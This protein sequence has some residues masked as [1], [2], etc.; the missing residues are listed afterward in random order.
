MNAMPDP[1]QPASG[2][3]GAAPVVPASGTSSTPPDVTAVMYRAIQLLITGMGSLNGFLKTISQS[4]LSMDLRIDQ[5]YADSL[6][7]I[8]LS[9]FPAGAAPS[10]P[11]HERISLYNQRQMMW[12]QVLQ[13]R[14]KTH[15]NQEQIDIQN[16]STTTSNEQQLASVI[17]SVLDL[18][19]Q[20]GTNINQMGK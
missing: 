4:L 12:Q 2:A 13:A 17:S 20:V 10:G 5:N 18:I 15:Q 16:A 3:S 7:N 8:H 1:N 11:S 9:S 14:L 6:S 19:T